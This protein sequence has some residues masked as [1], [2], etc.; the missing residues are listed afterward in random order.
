[1]IFRYT[2]YAYE[3]DPVYCFINFEKPCPQTLSNRFIFQFRDNRPNFQFRGRI[4][5]SPSRPGIILFDCPDILILV[6]LT[7]IW[8]PIFP[9]HFWYIQWWVCIYDNEA[10]LRSLRVTLAIRNNGL[11][12]SER[13]LPRFRPDLKCPSYTIKPEFKHVRNFM[14]FSWIKKS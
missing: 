5:M 10:H 7:L 3:S 9:F 4:S 6:G 11:H 14:A 8:L 13:P 1:M 2:V 12:K